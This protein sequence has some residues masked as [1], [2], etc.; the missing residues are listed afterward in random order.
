MK[1]LPR[2]IKR[3]SSHPCAVD[4]AQPSVAE[5]R[6]QTVTPESVARFGRAEFSLAA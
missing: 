4:S 6:M 3:Q 2:N 5:A 1:K